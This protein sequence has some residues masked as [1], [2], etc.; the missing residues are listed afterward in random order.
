MKEETT[1]R[2]YQAKVIGHVTTLLD[3]TLALYTRGCRAWSE[4]WLNVLG[5][6]DHDMVAH[7]PMSTYRLAKKA[8]A[9]RQ[10]SEIDGFIP[11]P[12]V[13][14]SNWFSLE[15]GDK[16]H[17]FTVAP[18]HVMPAFRRYLKSTTCPPDWLK[19]I[20][21]QIYSTRED[22]RWVDRRQFFSD[23]NRHIGMDRS[24]LAQILANPDFA[25]QEKKDVDAGKFSRDI[26]GIWWGNGDK[27]K[28]GDA[29]TIYEGLLH[30]AKS[31]GD[32]LRAAM[33]HHL[34][35]EP[36]PH[37]EALVYESLGCRG[38]PN[39]LCNFLSGQSNTDAH[40][41]VKMIEAQLGKSVY[42]STTAQRPWMKHLLAYLET[43]I[44]V[45][46][47]EDEVSRQAQFAQMSGLALEKLKSTRKNYYNQMVE[48]L[49][50]LD[51]PNPHPLVAAWIERYKTQK[52]QKGCLADNQVN[53]IVDVCHYWRGAKDLQAATT[54]AQQDLTG[55]P[56]HFDFF[57]YLAGQVQE[58]GHDKEEDWAKIILDYQKWDEDRHR[59]ASLRTP[60]FSHS[61]KESPARPWF[62]VS[63][64]TGQILDKTEVR[65]AGKVTVHHAL[66]NL[67][68]G[69]RFVDIEVPFVS[70]RMSREI[71]FCKDGTPVARNHSLVRQHLGLPVDAPVAVRQDRCGIMLDPVEK[72]GKRSWHL[73]FTFRLD[74]EKPLT[75]KEIAQLKPGLRIV[76]IDQGVREAAAYAVWEVVNRPWLPKTG[77][78]HVGTDAAVYRRLSDPKGDSYVWLRLVEDGFIRE[79]Q[80]I[81]QGPLQGKVRCRL[82][83]DIDTPINDNEASLWNKLKAKGILKYEC[84]KMALAFNRELAIACRRHLRG[85]IKAL[86]ESVPLGQDEMRKATVIVLAQKKPLDK[87]LLMTVINQAHSRVSIGGLSYRRI[88]TLQ[89]IKRACSAYLSVHPHD[90]DAAGY[91]VEFEQKLKEVRRERVR[92]VANKVLTVMIQHKARVLVIEDL[93]I[94]RSAKKAKELNR[95]IDVWCPKRVIQELQ[96]Q[97]QMYGFFVL[98]VAAQYTSHLDFAQDGKEA[99]SVRLRKGVPL[100][101]LLDKKWRGWLNRWSRPELWSTTDV[102][103]H[104]A[105]TTI[106][107]SWG[108]NGMADILDYANKNPD[109]KINA[110]CR[111]GGELILSAAH[112]EPIDADRNA[113]RTIGLRG[114]KTLLGW[115]DEKND[116]PKA[117]VVKTPRTSKKP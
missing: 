85:Q 61:T 113:A 104:D 99:Q 15:T 51:A 37:I 16:N 27:T 87:G 13:L 30:V 94:D 65:V 21:A 48:R 58:H 91:L 105:W 8:D 57:H 6:C 116:T 74:A 18:Y 20:E 47:F 11:V 100:K 46:Y 115:W 7:S 45:D 114:I 76:S 68:D 82:T 107:K 89:E 49:K 66:L 25:L 102:L 43:N 106:A 92:V 69:R 117:K 96:T 3:K 19:V 59:L 22:A 111:Q 108:L 72:D 63:R 10:K 1:P 98:P 39:A 35:V 67:Y 75:R 80:K 103:Y 70:D 41:V 12:V 23:W 79:R 32:N 40:A 97:A 81:N 88:R 4:V 9:T 34:G 14:F 31:N 90:Q 78:F 52:G 55:R 17:P 73:R 60:L 84:P 109:V 44:G 38:R 50:C 56:G 93:T 2:S 5:G 62:G 42:R 86:W 83:D 71:L 77:T 95:T 112:K 36:G 29:V 28:W 53:G 54:Q 24:D 33:L 64:P 101:A 110:P 26:T